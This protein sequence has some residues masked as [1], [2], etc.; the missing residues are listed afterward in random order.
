[1]SRIAHLVER[2]GN[3]LVLAFARITL[4][5]YVDLR[6]EGAER[7]PRAGATVVASRHYHFLFDALVLLRNTRRPAHF[8]TAV[9]WTRARWERLGMELLCRVT[10]WPIMLRVDQYSRP[11]FSSGHAAYALREAQPML[12]AAVRRAV[13]I[14]RAGET[15]LIFPEAYT[16]VD[17]FPTPKAD[18][19][20]FL[21][22]RPG[23]VKLAQIAERDDKTHVV[24]I[25]VGLSY[26]RLGKTRH[27]AWLPTFHPMWRI[28]MRF[29][30]PRTL[31]PSAHPAEV[32]ALRAQIE[33]E[34]R[35]LSEPARVPLAL[36]RPALG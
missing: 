20:D 2:A 31:P 16:N 33:R 10:G 19:P 26:E 23:F 7:L 34:V 6:V 1:M 8:W 12:R 13:R 15:L 3:G 28:T 27:P 9:D 36:T 32:A 14:L 22:F 21:P 18:G 24:I 35:A 17:I 11:H 4:A 5:L 29:G 25:P 30:E